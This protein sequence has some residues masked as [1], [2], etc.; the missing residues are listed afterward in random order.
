[1]PGLTVRPLTYSCTVGS[2]RTHES[3]VLISIA[4][5]RFCP[6]Q[7]VHVRRN[8]HDCEE[9]TE[10]PCLLPLQHLPPLHVRAIMVLTMRADVV[11]AHHLIACAIAVAAL[12]GKRSCSLAV[13]SLLIRV[14]GRP[15]TLGWA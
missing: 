11:Q 2:G 12:C 14:N 10:A 4:S 1:M 5:T 3:C 8:H 9:Y 13:T 6:Y 15:T 7:V